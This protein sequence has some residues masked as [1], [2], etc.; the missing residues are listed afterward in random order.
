MSSCL[1]GPSST[2][3][4][5]HPIISH[6]LLQALA[7]VEE[8]VKLAKRPDSGIK[9]ITFIVGRGLHSEDGIAKIKPAV[10]KLVNGWVCTT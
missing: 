8:N 3:D 9:A 10:M 5:F 6:C 7:K 1:I 2:V 4:G